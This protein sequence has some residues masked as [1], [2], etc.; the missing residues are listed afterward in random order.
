MS[1]RVFIDD[2]QM[3]CCG[4]PFTVGSTVTWTIFGRGGDPSPDSFAAELAAGFVGCCV[5]DR[6]DAPATLG[7][8]HH[9]RRWRTHPRSS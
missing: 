7:Q 5:A 1:E 8:H 6:R 3:Q 9:S 4:E 2:W